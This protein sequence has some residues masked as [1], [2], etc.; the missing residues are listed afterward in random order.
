MGAV[1][2][3]VGWDHELVMEFIGMTNIHGEEY[4]SFIVI[5][6]FFY[7]NISERLHGDQTNQR[8]ELSVIE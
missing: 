6:E 5:W 2:V 1:L 8:A 4:F 3:M 7:R